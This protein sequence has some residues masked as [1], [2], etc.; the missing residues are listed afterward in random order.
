M[1]FTRQTD[2]YAPTDPLLL[3]ATLKKDPKDVRDYTIGKVGFKLPESASLMQWQT[4]VKNQ[5]KLS[6]CGAFAGVAALEMLRKR[7][8]GSNLDLSELFLY[9]NARSHKDVDNGTYLRD[10]CK[11]LQKDGIALEQFWPYQQEKWKDEPN[12]A[13]QFAGKYIK[14]KGYYRCKD[15]D[16]IKGAITL[17]QPVLIG[18]K[19]YSDFLT[20]R[21]DT[22]TLNK[23][24]KSIGGHAMMVVGYSDYNVFVK[25]SWG[26]QWGKEGYTAL[27]P[28]Y[29]KKNLLDAWTVTL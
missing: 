10:V 19:I 1:I 27:S 5:G 15:I 14:I 13:A 3:K 29:V 28:S 2:K 25:N 7:F 11:S 20:L 12:F 6:S 21:D 9:Y 26:K 17:N 24:A 18:L 23:K 8:T 22:Y 4:P 16:S